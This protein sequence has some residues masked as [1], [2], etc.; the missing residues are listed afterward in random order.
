[1]YAVEQL[2]QCERY[3][4]WYGLDCAK[5]TNYDI[6]KVLDECEALH[7]FCNACNVKAVEAWAYSKSNQFPGVDLEKSGR[8]SQICHDFDVGL[9]SWDY[10]ALSWCAKYTDMQNMPI[11]GG[12]GACSSRKFWKLH[13]LR[14]N[15]RASLVIYQPLMFL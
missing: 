15:L 3:L 12:L 14:L 4:I 6:L 9:R 11:L 13:G 7:W 10:Y 5:V 2:L 8:H 1:M